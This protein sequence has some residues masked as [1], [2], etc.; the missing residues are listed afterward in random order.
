[1]YVMKI[2]VDQ[3]HLWSI[4]LG[5]TWYCTN[6]TLKK[7]NGENFFK[8]KIQTTAFKQIDDRMK[9]LVHAR[10]HE[11]NHFFNKYAV[12]R[13]SHVNKTQWTYENFYDFFFNDVWSKILV[14][15]EKKNV[16]VVATIKMKISGYTTNNNNKMV[17]KER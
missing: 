12:H 4:F 2:A 7:R 9:R 15:R 6:N 14:C 11:H 16:V 10:N 17:W 8:N 5:H 13:L 3:Y 1:M